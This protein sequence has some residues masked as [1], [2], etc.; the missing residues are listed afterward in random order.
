MGTVVEKIIYQIIRIDHRMKKLLQINISVNRGSTGKIVE[1]IGTTAQKH[2]WESFVGYGNYNLNSQLKAIHISN[3][4]FKLLHAVESRLFDNH[5][6]S[7]RLAT[8]RFIRIIRKIQPD[9][10]HLHNIHGYYLNYKI[11]F[12]YLKTTTI[13]VVWTFHDCWAFTGH[14]GYFDKAA[15]SRWKSGCYAPC[16]C[17]KEYPKSILLDRSNNNYDLKKRLFTSIEDRLTVVPVSFWL[18]QFVHQS[19]LQNSSIR[20]IH[21]GIDTTV[22][23][24]KN[25][26]RLRKE[27]GIGDKKVALGVASPWVPRKG[28]IDMFRLSEILS[29]EDYQVIMVGVSEKQLSELPSGIIG[30]KRTN[31]A[32]ELAEYYS[33]AEVF[34]NP[35]YEDNFPT[36]NLEAL[37]CGTPII[38]YRTGG[39]PEAVTPETGWVLE[40]GDVDGIANIVR[41]IATLPAE[42]RDA[43]SKECRTRA[44]KEFDK[45]NCFEKYIELYNEL[46]S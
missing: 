8:Y 43:Q 9:V 45:N 16:P 35:T 27:L 21:N 38:T 19:F 10:I 36:T 29:T 26:E 28:Y 42:Q 33:L 39:S 44:E 3:K 20:T 41:R 18:E 13:P 30:V 37:A 12:D 6:L 14:C 4:F 5:G 34:V 32:A 17:R 15:C 2:G 23:C 11:L 24:P 46:L 31:S 25:T 1:Q 7:S 40:Q 22:F